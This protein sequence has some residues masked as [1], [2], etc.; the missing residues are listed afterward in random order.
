MTK[1]SAVAPNNAATTI[2]TFPS[3]SSRPFFFPNS[4][5]APPAIEPERPALLP[6]CRT[7]AAIRTIERTTWRAVTAIFTAY[8][9]PLYS[10]VLNPGSLNYYNKFKIALWPSMP[11]IYRQHT[12]DKQKKY[13]AIPGFR[14]KNRINYNILQNN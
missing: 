4:V 7:T 10:K 1:L 3:N 11:A 12:A 2:V 8:S 14:V 5:S 9:P 13:I 6:D